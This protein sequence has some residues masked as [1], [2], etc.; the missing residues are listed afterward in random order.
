MNSRPYFVDWALEH[1][2]VLLRV[3][4]INKVFTETVVTVPY[5]LGLFLFSP[6]RSFKQNV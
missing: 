5:H 6:Y 4:T 2:I 1:C 3:L